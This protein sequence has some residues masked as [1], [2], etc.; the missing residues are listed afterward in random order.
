MKK[1]FIYIS[2]LTLLMSAT[3]CNDYLD[4]SSSSNT[5]DNFVT[6]TTAET[7]K[8][9]SWAYAN[10]AN[11]CASGGNYGYNDPVGSD[12]EMY[13]ELNSSNNNNAKLKPESETIG[14]KQTQ[15]NNLYNCLARAARVANIIKEKQEY[16]DDVIAGTTSMW[17]QLY[18]EAVTFRAYCYFELVKHWGDVPYGIENTVVSDYS[19]TSRFDIYDHIIEDVKAVEP[20]MYRLGESNLTAERITRTFANELI[21]EAALY[22]S[23]WQTIRTDVSGLYG[24]VQ[25]TA[26]GNDANGCIYARRTDYQKY[27]E[28]AKTYFDATLNAQKGTSKLITTD[29]RTYCNNPFQRHFQYFADLKISPESIFEIGVQQ[30]IQSEYPYSQGR[31]SNGGGSNACPTKTFGAIRIIPYFY[32][33]GFEDGDK[34]MDASMTVTGSAGTGNEMILSF[35][36]GNK[37]N[38]GISINKWDDNRMNP[39]YV[40]AQRQSGINYH[41]SRVADVMLMQAEVKA[42][43]GESTDAISLVN[44]IRER[45][46]GNSNHNLALSISGEALKDSVYKERERELLGEGDIRWDMIRSGKFTERTNAIRANMKAMIAGLEANGYYKFPNGRIIP[47]YIWTKSVY[48]KNPLTYD[49]DASD[50]ALFPGWRGQFDY[51]TISTVASKVTGTNHNLAIKGLFEYIDPNGEEAKA[52]EADGY[53]KTAWGATIVSEKDGIY[54]SNIL[55]GLGTSGNAPRYYHPIPY[56]TINQ[57][58]GKVTNGYGLPQK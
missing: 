18:G 3:G 51:T 39:P 35:K 4:V 54:D 15:F 27:L 53:T 28:I 57:S 11:N 24:D 56:E 40:A 50:P 2:A 7:F 9:L 55:S 43:L 58:K 10:Y 1:I 37:C 5:D 8:T 26:Q 47:A 13:P 22:A 19:L 36:N 41:V 31:P 42:E 45:A 44:Q 49:A 46:Y 34:R 14:A 6:S 25:F 17:T 30:T 32:Y 33:T 16:K 38:G 23:G 52:L 20:L 48:K 12:C 21:A 29:E